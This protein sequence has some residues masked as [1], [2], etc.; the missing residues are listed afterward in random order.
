MDRDSLRSS[1]LRIKL[2]RPN[3]AVLAVALAVTFFSLIPYV[4]AAIS[5]EVQG[6]AGGEWIEVYGLPK[7]ALL[8]E[9]GRSD[10]KKLSRTIQV[11]VGSEGPAD[12]PP[13]LGTY[14]VRDNKLVFEPRFPFKS[15]GTY[16]A[17]INT[18]DGEQAVTQVFTVGEA[19]QRKAAFVEEIFPSRDVLPENQLKFY[20]HFS[21]PMSQ[22]DVYD[23]V[24][25]FALGN[26]EIAVPFV[27]VGQE[28]WDRSGT[29]I[30]LLLDPG[31]IKRGLKPREDLG[32]ILTEGE[33]YVLEI[34]ERW[35]DANG[36]L[37][38][39]G[40][41]KRFRVDSPD[42][43]QPDPSRWKLHEPSAG[44]REPLQLQFDEPLDHA[45][46]FRVL[47]V[48]DESEQRVQGKI[49]VL[50]E[51]TRWQ[52]SPHAAW[53]SGKYEIVVE[54]ILEDLAGNSIERPFEVDIFN[55]IETSIEQPTVSIPFAVK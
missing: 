20:V 19:P 45:M 1:R 9:E 36:N 21:A 41:Q 38:R 47:T 54:T 44:T 16:R 55:R 6:S 22:G 10:V 30:T 29:R 26:D 32:P 34:D 40:F 46:L 53:K 18:G 33:S 27:N 25:L 48:V 15:G 7:E 37:L 51:Q 2:S 28:L 52:F 23:R 35:R 39:S 4:H 49:R 43:T 31:R 17:V 12:Q 50:D 8:Q 14:R 11:L 42:E 24:R 13:V 3:A 5:V